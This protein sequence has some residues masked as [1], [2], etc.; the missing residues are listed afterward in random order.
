MTTRFI[1]LD[2]NGARNVILN[3]IGHDVLHDF[4]TMNLRWKQVTPEISQIYSATQEDTHGGSGKTRKREDDFM[5]VVGEEDDFMNREGERKKVKP[6]VPVV[7][8]KAAAAK[9]GDLMHVVPVYKNGKEIAQHT[10]VPVVEYEAAAAAKTGHVMNVV[11]EEEDDLMH[12]V[13]VYKYDKKFA[14]HT[15]VPVVE[16]E[17]SAAK[18]GDLMDVDRAEKELDTATNIP[19]KEEAAAAEE[20]A[21]SESKQDV[22]LQYDVLSKLNELKL[23]L[24][25][26]IIMFFFYLAIV[27]RDNN[28]TIMISLEYAILLIEDMPEMQAVTITNPLYISMYNDISELFWE[29]SNS[30]NLLTMPINELFV[31]D[32]PNVIEEFFKECEDDII[33]IIAISLPVPEPVPE[34]EPEPLPLPEPEPVPVIPGGSSKQLGGTIIIPQ[35]SIDALKEALKDPEDPEDPEDREIPR[36]INLMQTISNI[37]MDQVTRHVDPAYEIGRYNNTREELKNKLTII[38]QPYY[39]GSYLK[40]LWDTFI[41]E[42]PTRGWGERTGS[43]NVQQEY[44]AGIEKIFKT[45]TKVSVRK[46]PQRQAID[47]LTQN[48][49]LIKQN[50]IALSG[51]GTK[52]FVRSF[53][54]FIAKSALILTQCVDENGVKILRIDPEVTP[55][56]EDQILNNQ[57]DILLK[58][59]EWTTMVDHPSASS[60]D[61]ELYEYYYNKVKT[62]TNNK[63]TVK[64]CDARNRYIINNAAPLNQALSERAFCTYTSILDGMP[65]C[66]WGPNSEG[67]REWGNMDFCITSGVNPP[68]FIEPMVPQ[69]DQLYYRGR[70]KISG[71]PFDKVNLNIDLNLF[72]TQISGGIPLISLDQESPLTAARVLSAMLT[73]ILLSVISTITDISTIAGA[74]GIWS[75][76]YANRM[77]EI[78]DP[79]SAVPKPISILAFILRRILLKGVGD[80]FQ[81]INAVCKYGGYSDG[82]SYDYDDRQ[83]DRIMQYDAH[84]D[85]FR[86]FTASDRPSGTR[87][88]F[89]LLFG[90]PS[91]INLRAYGGYFSRLDSSLRRRSELIAVEPSYNPCL[92]TSYFGGGKRRQTKKRRRKYQ[93]KKKNRI[94]G[95]KRTKKKYLKLMRK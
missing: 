82:P 8:Y 86:L 57:I 15:G 27:Q 48:L 2:N 62:D 45:M 14:E 55:V 43:I 47:P 51:E 6:G 75:W 58:C 80:I 64:P 32:T 84:G 72:G 93:S 30:N 70:L 29:Y 25:N 44:D 83:D 94:L 60:I 85:A 53:V 20:A 79:L 10:G 78:Q 68:N 9:T 41:R 74:G 1:H 17:A 16:D 67:R 23:T 35:E 34:P 87:F 4:G 22:T 52:D 91:E 21:K 61:K 63:V 90:Q 92:G 81:E 5:N 31:Q 37:V 73:D 38:F 77:G 36:I 54:Q 33:N 26:E 7:E 18:I 11:E 76:L 56:S 65:H 13:P 95:S 59:T 71:A 28:N 69:A 50:V 49:A 46:R 19:T 3:I 40:P 12:M 89:L 88:I 42:M 39:A 24:E 66:N